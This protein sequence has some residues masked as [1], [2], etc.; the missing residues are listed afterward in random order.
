[1]EVN[2]GASTA[3]LLELEEVEMAAEKGSKRVRVDRADESSTQVRLP[4]RAIARFTSWPCALP[5]PLLA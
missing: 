2:D 5:C 1:M 4:A 3:F